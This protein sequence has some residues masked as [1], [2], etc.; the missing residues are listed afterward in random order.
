[1]KY[2]LSLLLVFCL[3]GISGFS[4]LFINLP[5]TSYTI[6]FDGTVIGVIQGTNEGKGFLASPDDGYLDADAWETSGMSDGNTLFGQDNA[7]KGDFTN[8][9]DRGGVTT[10]GFWAFNVLKNDDDFTFGFQPTDADFTPGYITLKIRN[11]TGEYVVRMLLAYEIWVNNDSDYS[12]GISLSYSLDNQN[13]IP[14]SGVDFFSAAEQTYTIPELAGNEN[15]EKQDIAA[16][17]E[18]LALPDGSDIYLRW[19][20]QDAALYNVFNEG[21]ERDEFAL[22]DISVLVETSNNPGPF[23]QLTDYLRYPATTDVVPVIAEITDV[24]N[25]VDA[26]NVWIKYG[27]ES[28]NYSDSVS[29]SYTSGNTYT[30]SIPAIFPDSTKVYFVVEAKDV[31]GATGQSIENAYEVRD[32]Y[33]INLPYEQNFDVDLGDCYIFNV[34]GNQKE[35]YWGR[36]FASGDYDEYA[37]MTGYSANDS[38]EDWLI[39]PGFLLSPS[40]TDI[41]DFISYYNYGEDGVGTFQLMVSTDYPGIGDP[42]AYI[43]TEKQFQ[44][45]SRKK[46]WWYSEQVLLPQGSDTLF[47][48]FK[49]TSPPQSP[50]TWRVDQ[51]RITR[52][53]SADPEPVSYPSEFTATA[54]NGSTI[55][56]TWTDVTDPIPP[57]GYHIQVNTSNNFTPPVDGIPGPVDF[58]LR[59]GVGSTNVFHG[60]FEEVTWTN[61]NPS[62]TY[63]FTIYS[64]S[65]SGDLIDFKTDGTP[66]ATQAITTTGSSADPDDVIMT[67]FMASPFDVND[68]DGEWIE[69]FNTTDSDIDLDG[70]I[71][72]S[73]AGSG[74]ELHSIVNGGPLIIKAND[75]LVIGLNDDTL[76]NNG[77]PVAY[78]YDN[79]FLSN[80]FDTIQIISDAR[81][82]ID[83]LEWGDGSVWGIPLGQSLQ[84]VAT[85]D[86]DNNNGFNWTPALIRENGY[87][88]LIQTPGDIA[89]T[90]RGSPGTN[91]LYQ[92]LVDSTTWTGTG[93]WSVGNRVG[94]S[95]WSNGSPG[96]NVKVIIKGEVEVDLPKVL[97]ALSGELVIDPVI[98]KLVIPPQKALTTN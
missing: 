12:G 2:K 17:I 37:E 30:G 18:G 40:N 47:V 33:I 9:Q 74:D 56:T 82:E 60:G 90:D 65:N 42:S 22:D 69:L 52:D 11:N 25:P 23:V 48:A 95:N 46:Q 8:G 43:W 41:I 35:W 13:F 62:T 87:V 85:A 38:E 57:F 97:P 49:Y 88:D 34:L 21:G 86:K 15:W 66:P 36:D 70:W 3:I 67:E 58:D 1:M 77:V 44:R 45:P 55:R 83:F 39:L 16:L 31:N 19:T 79:V 29:M 5:N 27:T 84:F 94:K 75:F 54:F 89:E 72:R 53:Q 92:N 81:V 76:T 32:P 73:T 78:E 20:H 71:L 63:Y 24:N 61:L 51:I 28:E 68:S 59:D 93:A 26:S 50:R 14:L 4:Q 64:Y 98:G 7:S 6:D 10:G 96:S 80:T 91:G